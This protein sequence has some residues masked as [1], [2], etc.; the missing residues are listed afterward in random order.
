MC[1]FDA[2]K[3]LVDYEGS[4]KQLKRWEQELL[5]YNF[6][7][8]HRSCKFMRDVDALNRQYSNPLIAQYMA[9]SATLHQESLQSH[10]ESY[11]FPSLRYLTHKMAAAPPPASHYNAS[12]SLNVAVQCLTVSAPM[13]RPVYDTAASF[14]TATR[15]EI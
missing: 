1:D 4:I 12:E 15:S 10:L 5:G 13:M 14:V 9:K 2:I 3:S 8:L 11:A 6:T 7:V